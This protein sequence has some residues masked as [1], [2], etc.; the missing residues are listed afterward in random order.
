M[1]FDAWTQPCELALGEVPAG[2]RGP[3]EHM[4]FLNESHALLLSA[5]GLYLFQPV[6]VWDLLASKSFRT[7]GATLWEGRVLYMY[8]P[9]SDEIHAASG[10][11]WD[12]ISRVAGGFAGDAV[13]H[14]LFYGSARLSPGTLWLAVCDPS[15]IQ[16]RVLFPAH[17]W[18]VFHRHSRTRESSSIGTAARPL[19]A[20]LSAPADPLAGPWVLTIDFD[21]SEVYTLS[22]NRVVDEL[23]ITKELSR[24]YQGITKELEFWDALAGAFFARVSHARLTVSPLLDDFAWAPEKRGGGMA[25]AAIAPVPSS[26]FISRWF[27]S[28]SQRGTY[29]AFESLEWRNR[30]RTLGIGAASFLRNESAGLF[31]AP[32]CYDVLRPAS[33]CSEVTLH[34]LLLNASAAHPESVGDPV[35][36]AALLGRAVDD[37]CGP[38]EDVFGAIHPLTGALWLARG[39]S[40]F[41]VARTGA[42]RVVDRRGRCAPS[43]GGLCAPGQ[44]GEPGGVCVNVGRGSVRALPGNEP[45]RESDECRLE[46]STTGEAMCAER[47][48][49]IAAHVSGLPESASGFTAG[50][51][52]AA[53]VLAGDDPAGAIRVLLELQSGTTAWRFAV[54]PHLVCYTVVALAS[55]PLA[56]AVTASAV[57][58][59]P[60]HGWS[61]LGLLSV[62]GLGLCGGLSGFVVLVA[63]TPPGVRRNGYS[64]ARI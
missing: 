51:V 17:S 28:V 24:N 49:A 46:W 38:A 42:Q 7:S 6:L 18:V 16:I 37:A 35:A 41:E 57:T 60:A 1:D 33:A 14:G 11:L 50:R 39:S 40:V 63:Q 61:F 26:H 3:V 19:K 9:G 2:F 30:P 8:A 15:G 22:S 32:A 13:G 20:T 48:L 56:S 59:W 43:A 23:R 31:G 5:D 54:P 21:T 55:E 34:D 47:G 4:S 25:P 58:V 53:R 27:L 52:C 64:Y 36:L 10:P 29:S 45:Q 44:W 62:L 12:N